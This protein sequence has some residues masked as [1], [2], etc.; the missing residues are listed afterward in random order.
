MTAENST[1]QMRKGI[2]EYCVLLIIARGEVYASDLIDEMKAA[3]IIVVEGTL[4]HLLN[5]LLRS[6]HLTYAWKESNA[7][8]PR[9]YYQ[10][11][12]KGEEHLQNQIVV[13]NEMTA[14][15]EAIKNPIPK[16]DE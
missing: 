9:K 8:P 11:S 14:S 4:Y 10:L 15:I 1:T 3:K 7:G 13:W 2:L 12:E 6:E 5:R 16:N